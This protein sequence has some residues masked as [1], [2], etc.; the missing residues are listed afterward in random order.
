MIQI[1][2]FLHN[3]GSSVEP[4]EISECYNQEAEGKANTLLKTI[5]EYCKY[6]RE[7]DLQISGVDNQTMS[8]IQPLLSKLKYLYL[9]FVCGSDFG[10]SNDF[11]S[12]CTQLN[13][14][15]LTGCQSSDKFA[16]PNVNF[17]KI[18]F[19]INSNNTCVSNFN[20]SIKINNFNYP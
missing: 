13:T 20:K 4:W 8:E 2:N 18:K 15:G 9:G 10:S 17:P 19:K 3:F 5:H 11:I 14:L 1:E 12:A 6:L 16:L 7:L